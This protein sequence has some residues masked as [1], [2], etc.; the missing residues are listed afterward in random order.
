M[1]KII[2]A[3]KAHTCEVCA[4]IIHPKKK[5][6]LSESREPKFNIEGEQIGVEF[7]RFRICIDCH[8]T[9]DTEPDNPEME[10]HG[11]KIP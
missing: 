6:C 3:R 9:L 10:F 2:K 7:I 5:Y 4:G 1:D 11:I 8:N